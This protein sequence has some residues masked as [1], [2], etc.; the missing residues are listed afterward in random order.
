MQKVPLLKTELI[1]AVYFKVSGMLFP[2][3]ERREGSCPLYK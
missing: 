1:F 3:D 2:R